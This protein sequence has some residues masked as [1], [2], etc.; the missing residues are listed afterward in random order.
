MGHLY[1]GYVSHNQRIIEN[2]MAII[3]GGFSRQPCWITR[4]HPMV[5]IQ[6]LNGKS[7]GTCTV[8]RCFPLEYLD[9]RPCLIA[10][11]RVFRSKK[12]N[13]AASHVT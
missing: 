12:V 10:M 7:G 2:S 4:G 13:G 6:P 5:S 11:F 1:Q 9:S 3:H 8:C